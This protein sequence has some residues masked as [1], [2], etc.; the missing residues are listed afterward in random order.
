MKWYSSDRIASLMGNGLLTCTRTEADL[1]EIYGED[2]MIY[3]NNT[4]DLIHQLNET[5]TGDRWKEIAKNGWEVN[6]KY[7]N[8]RDITAFMVEYIMDINCPQRL[9]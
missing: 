3:Y 8:S 6:H 9:R 5:L 1:H 2:S 7:F 4:E